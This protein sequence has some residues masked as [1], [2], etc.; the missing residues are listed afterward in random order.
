MKKLLFN[1]N[2]DEN[3]FQREVQCLMKVKHKNIVRFLGYC[4]DLQGNMAK[5]DGKLVMADVQ[6]RLLCFEYLPNGTVHDY[7]TGREISCHVT[8]IYEDLKNTNIIPKA[9]WSITFADASCRLQWRTCY[10]IIKGI[11]NGL[12]H[13]HDNHIIHLDLK[14]LN[15]LL[16]EH[17]VPKIADF[18]LSRCFDENQSHTITSKVIGSL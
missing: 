7:I 13:L 18:G 2:M 11:C 15:V 9:K 12:H 6:Q 17:M 5:Y 3:E 14:P 4:A 16:D 8:T 10:K 1:I